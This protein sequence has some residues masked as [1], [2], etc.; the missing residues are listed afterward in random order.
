MGSEMCIR[1]RSYTLLAYDILSPSLYCFWLWYF[2]QYSS[3]IPRISCLAS[4]SFLLS[5]IS[6]SLSYFINSFPACYA[7]NS[8]ISLSIHATTSPPAAYTF[9]HSTLFSIAVSKFHLGF[10][11]NVV[12][13]FEQSSFKKLAS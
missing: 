1:D 7:K 2:L 5:N 6:Y 4:N 9:D 10:Q 3:T 13:N 12:F 11:P 8:S